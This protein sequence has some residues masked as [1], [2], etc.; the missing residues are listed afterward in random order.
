[1]ELTSISIVLI[2]FGTALLAIFLV[3]VCYLLAIL[4]FDYLPYEEPEE[5]KPLLSKKQ[6]QN[7]SIFS[8]GQYDLAF[9]MSELIKKMRINE[10]QLIEIAEDLKFTDNYDFL[11]KKLI[12]DL[13]KEI[14]NNI[15]GMI[16]DER[17]N[18]QNPENDFMS[19]E[20]YNF[21]SSNNE[22][23]DVYKNIDENLDKHLINIFKMEKEL[24]GF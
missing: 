1:M 15:K 21:V 23:L 4:F 17:K 24:D 13:K 22:A 7:L 16:S 20:E 14:T 18:F 19:E 5:E 12:K 11:S 3:E 8:R 10:E 6:I 2:F 9:Q